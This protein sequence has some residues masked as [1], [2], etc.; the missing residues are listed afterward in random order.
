M[1]SGVR[2]DGMENL[3]YKLHKFCSLYK[4]IR[5]IQKYTLEVSLDRKTD[6]LRQKFLIYCWPDCMDKKLKVFKVSEATSYFYWTT[7]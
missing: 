3:K 1:D 7:A 6:A 4:K 5:A 2:I